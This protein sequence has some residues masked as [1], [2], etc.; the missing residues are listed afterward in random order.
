MRSDAYTRAAEPRHATDPIPGTVQNHDGGA[1]FD[2]G[3]LAQARRFL[4]IG[5]TGGTYYQGE[6]EYTRENVDVIFRLAQERPAELIELIAD[7]SERGLAPKLAPQLAALAVCTSQPG[8][9]R[10]LAFA[11]FGR[12]VRTGSHLLTWARYHKA[13]G[14]GVGRAWRRAVAHWYLVRDADALAYQLAKYRQRDGWSQKDLIDMSHALSGEVPAAKAAALRWARDE[15]SGWMPDLLAALDAEVGYTVADLIA[16]GASWE[17]LPDAEL[18]KAETWRLLLAEHKLP[19]G[20]AIR[21]LPRMT[22]VGALTPFFDTAADKAVAS[23]FDDER[24][25][26]G[27]RIHPMNVLLAAKQYS[28]GQSRSGLNYTPIPG[29]LSMLDRAF[30]TAFE[31]AEASGKRH[32]VGIDISSSMRGATP[33]GV[34]SHEVATVLAMKILRTE[35]SSYVVGFARQVQELGMTASM[36]LAAALRTTQGAFGSTNPGALIDYAFQRKLE[37]DTFVVITDNEV[38]TGYHVPDVLRAY[39]KVMGIDA[40]LVVIATTATRFSIADPKDPGMLDVAGFGADVPALLTA[41]SR[42][43]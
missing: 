14:G 17:M 33:L 37:V 23:M 21:Q 39:R 28:R 18:R 42:G 27:A 7:I 26:R 38:N 20:A 5:T 35:P 3:D 4:L 1:V 2:I 41:F 12:I 43:L 13:F 16:V 40:K 32:L 9:A 15:H 30:Y 10:I 19:L 24:A 29:V 34:T 36:D 31:T 25:L 6:R 22:E 8:P 11:E